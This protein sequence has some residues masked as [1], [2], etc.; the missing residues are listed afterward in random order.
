MKKGGVCGKKNLIEFLNKNGVKK[1]PKNCKTSC[2]IDKAAEVYKKKKMPSREFNYLYCE[3]DIC[4]LKRRLQNR[5]LSKSGTKSDMIKR[6]ARNDHIH[7]KAV[8]RALRNRK[9]R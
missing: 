9:K 4:E 3:H 7:K 5:N 1:I 8:E 2:L 6:L